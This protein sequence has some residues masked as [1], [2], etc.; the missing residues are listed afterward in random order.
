LVVLWGSEWRS[1]QAAIILHGSAVGQGIEDKEIAMPSPETPT[2]VVLGGINGAGKTSSA[3][4]IVRNA[5]GI[6]RFV[7]ADTIA[8]GL[9]AFDP[10]S[11]AAKV[12]RI[13]LDHLHDLA[14]RQKSFAFETTLAARSYARWL[15]SLRALGYVCHLFYFWLNSA[16]LAVSRVA[17][18]VRAGG[19][20]IP[21]G[22]IR[23]RYARSARN[24][25]DLY[26]SVVTTWQLYDNSNGRP[27]LIAVNN[28]YF[29]TILDPDAWAQFTRSAGNDPVNY[30]ADI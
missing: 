27:R 13:M 10:E 14:S 7:N 29:D 5:I 20:H 1:R 16:D 25:L 24:F 8:R 19:H 12:G 21:E 23:R 9:N 2:V 3:L 28:S 22:T 26:R 4:P 30:P 6:P 17:E 18:R 11:E 15:E